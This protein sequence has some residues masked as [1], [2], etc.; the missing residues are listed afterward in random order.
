M[1]QKPRNPFNRIQD[2]LA[3]SALALSLAISSPSLV[4]APLY[5]DGGGSTPDADGGSGVWD[6]AT[7][8]WDDAPIAGADR[9]WT[10]VADLANFGG[11]GGTVTTNTS[12]GALGM[13]FTTP[14]YSL[15]GTGVLTLAGSGINTS[16][17]VS[18]TTTL[19]TALTLSAGQTWNIGAGNILNVGGGVTGAGGLIVSGGVTNFTGSALSP[20]KF[21][22]TGGTVFNTSGT[23]NVTAGSYF[24]VGDGGNATLNVTGGSFSTNQT[25]FLATAADSSLAT[26]KLRISAGTFNMTGAAINIGAGYNNNANGTGILTVEGTG[27]FNTGT[28]GNTVRLGNNSFGSGTV[29]LNGGT[30]ATN[31][32][33]APSTAIPTGAGTKASIFNFNGGTLKANGTHL[34]LSNAVVTNVRNGGAIVDSNSFNVSI[35]GNLGHS[36]ISGDQANDG[37]LVKNGTGILALGGTN[38]F[39][40]NVTVQAGDL[41]GKV[42]TALPGFATSGRYTVAAGAGL[43]GRVGGA[44]F[45]DPDFATLL[46]S[47][48][49]APGSVVFVDTTN[50]NY[51][52][53]ANLGTA[54]SAGTSVGLSKGGGNNLTLDLASQTFTGNI[55][56]LGGTLILDS[57]A[58]VS[59]AGTINGTSNLTKLGAGTLSLT[60]GPST[61]V[62]LLTDG[63]AINLGGTFTSRKLIVRL[64]ATINSSGIVTN[65]GDYTGIGDGS[66]G[67]L[68]VTGGTFTSNNATY[69][70][71]VG[72]N[73]GTGNL[74]I[75][76]G[77]FVVGTSTP[78]R[79]G[80][81]YDGGVARI[82]GNGT[83]TVSGSGVFDTGTTSG[84]LYLGSSN[85]TLA[86][87]G[88]INFN[89]GTFVTNRP[90]TKGN[91]LA[92]A[93][94]NFNGGTFK[95]GGTSASI[96][97]SITTNVRNGGAIID[98]N[99]SYIYLGANLTHSAISG[100]AAIDGGLV[101]TGDGTLDLF[102][103]DATYTG[104]T[105]VRQGTLVISTAFL[106]DGSGVVVN[107]GGLLDIETG[108]TDTVKTLV[109][110]GAPAAVGTWGGPDAYVATNH[111]S[112]SILGSGV[113]KVTQLATTSSFSTWISSYPSLTGSDA[114]P[115]AD[116]DKDGLSNLMEFAL[117]GDPANGTNRGLSKVVIQ[118]ASLPAGKELTL[119]TAVRRGA[120]FAAVAGASQA[121]TKDG[122]VYDIQGSLDLGNF[123][124]AVSHIS[125]SNTAGGLPDLTGT[126]WEY[127][128][129]KLDASEGLSGK[130]F[131]RTHIGSAP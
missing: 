107:P 34:N 120:T 72:N 11:A 79:I 22:L 108:D 9:V 116:P 100:D 62:Q 110:D 80:D 14:G 49:F 58:N 48:N 129:F 64:G 102:G 28:T 86:S 88:T 1:K 31:F 2:R 73:S 32:D 109:I 36:A 97:N 83:L 53:T 43:G 124:S 121:A 23:G 90:I 122:V 35:D 89:G 101:K 125:A 51:V 69:A 65:S 3:S 19:N 47:G 16:A 71:F 106:A 46:S 20:A 87:T 68:N 111:T 103:T 8:N 75:S 55:R 42:P 25:L 26:G 40:G 78:V 37:G 76:G 104:N 70:L 93:V 45:A 114:L 94:V 21:S 81:S 67:T 123:T 85:P 24:G 52:L 82:P 84:A 54:T 117:K 38:T 105:T 60:G 5:W 7:P 33:F 29:N 98:T 18:G 27:L 77:S 112:P 119:V 96:A 30:L 44:G 113:L 91:G 50:G 4:A 12:L 131:L 130:G 74:N 128:T 92:T 126:D 39:T 6:L 118:D 56:S 66:D 115:G 99:G 59:Y 61:V 10:G 127:H 57:A 41:G 15:S 13:V 17:L 63:G 95:A